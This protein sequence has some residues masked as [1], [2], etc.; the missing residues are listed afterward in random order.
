MH[1]VIEAPAV[2]FG[3]SPLQIATTILFPAAI[4]ALVYALM[5]VSTPRDDLG[6]WPPVE[7]RPVSGRAGHSGRRST[8][9]PVIDLRA[10]SAPAA[11]CPT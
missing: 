7:R 5:A 10:R 4:A 8:V 3:H 9:R 6:A 1:Y 2:F 11:P